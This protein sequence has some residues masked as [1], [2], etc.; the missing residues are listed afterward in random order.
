LIRF[1]TAKRGIAGFVH[2]RFYRA[3]GTYP[4]ATPI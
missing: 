1:M 4:I 2:R 3:T